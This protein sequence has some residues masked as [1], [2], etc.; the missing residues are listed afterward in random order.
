MFEKEFFFFDE[1][2]VHWNILEAEEALRQ[3]DKGQFNELKSFGK[4]PLACLAIFEG[5]GILLDPSKDV[6]EWTDDKKL[7]AGSKDQFL[8]RLFQ[9][10]KNNINDKQLEKVKS[11][12]DRDDCQPTQLA[13]IS[14]VCDK[15]G[16]WLRAILAY[17]TQRQKSS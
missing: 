10:D 7:M 17:A 12:L 16:L 4:P 3:L 11:I 6:W 8:E 5:I 14:A 2:I 13:R 1:I 15:L 9:F